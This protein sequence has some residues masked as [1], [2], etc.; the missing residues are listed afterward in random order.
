MT[1]ALTYPY[2]EPAVV[3][4]EAEF[5][6]VV[7]EVAEGILRASGTSFLVVPKFG[8]DV[9][10][11]IRGANGTTMKM[12]EFKCFAGA[13]PGCVGFGTP[14]G[15]GPQ[16]ELL[17]QAEADLETVTPVLRWALVDALLPIGSKRYALFD[18]VT[19]KAGAMGEVKHG[20]QNNFRVA[21]FRP[22]MADW[23]VFV[24]AIQR[25]LTA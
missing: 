19:A 10:F 2:P 25:F 4:P 17:R 7:I 9:A 12:L 8:V 5:E 13:R 15:G 23:P 24:A 22:Q 6:R 20:K 16:V 14:Q 11:F 3:A 21:A 18:S 1:L